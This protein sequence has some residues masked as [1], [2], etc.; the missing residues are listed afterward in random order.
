MSAPTYPSLAAWHRRLAAGVLGE[1]A[2]RPSTWRDDV[3]YRAACLEANA[4]DADRQG[5][6]SAA[7]EWRAAVE[8]LKATARAH[9]G[10]ANAA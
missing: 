5:L 7:A 3:L 1:D 6:V 8:E 4:R 2:A 9:R 10:T